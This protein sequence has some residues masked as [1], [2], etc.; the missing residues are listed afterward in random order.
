[1]G[2]AS[3]SVLA[4]L[5]IIIFIVMNSTGAIANIGM[6][7]FI[8]GNTWK[9]SS[10]EYGAVP[11]I[12]GTI[13]V[14]VGSVAFAVPLGIGAA[15][16]ISE[17]ADSKK[18]KFLKPIVELF[19]GIPSVVYGFIGLTLMTPFFGNL[20]PEQMPTGF[21]WITGSI[22]LGLMALPTIISVSEDSIKAVP[23]SYREASLAMGATKWETTMKVVVPA[24]ISGIS[25]AV[26]LGIGRAMG[27]T[28]AVMMVTGNAA[29]IPEPLWNIFSMVRTITASLAL[30]MPEVVVGSVH[31]SSLFLLALILMFL[32]LVINIIAKLIVNHT[33]R[34][35]EAGDQKETKITKILEKINTHPQKKTISKILGNTA[36]FVLVFLMASLFTNI[37]ESSLIALTAMFVTMALKQVYKK[38]NSKIQEK[39]SH[40][41]LFF[42]V[43]LVCVVL[44]IILG[45]ICIKGIPALSW[46][47]ITQ[48]PE[49][50]FTSGGIY[51]AI[52]GTLEL[53]VGTALISIPL[54]LLTG[55]YLAE[56][57]G[58]TKI[59][60]MIRWASDLLNGT[61][62]V[63][64]GLFGM[65]ALVIFL[66]MGQS[67]IAG[68][69]TLSIMA[70]PVIIRTTEE[71][72]KSVPVELREA[73][74]GMG[75]TKW[76]TVSRVVIPSAIGGI[77]TGSILSLGR[78]VGETAPIMF[79]A[80]VLM[81][82]QLAS[83]I[84]EPIMALPY[85]LYYLASEGRADPS[86]QY[87]TALV[88]LIIV[89]AMFLSA[90]YI[91]ERNNKGE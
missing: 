39:I 87:G 31:Y 76:Q 48:F 4:I 58:D 79:T 67:L 64:F 71:A 65:T 17:V 66:D 50:G 12:L 26:I 24:A 16:Y 57:A 33:K 13:L 55:V 60:N 37:F 56:Y 11:V 6:W 19:A 44:V 34:K 62:S 75:A 40:N 84:F 83:S 8:T 46:D 88:L 74:M 80:T 81:Q 90:N 61:P 23:R 2:I 29:V 35:F 30:E 18:R 22:L 28:M 9:P 25:A 85:L 59:S 53:L 41:I 1:M 10:E 38:Q 51:P 82:S 69:I 89:L 68:C 91:R 45:N 15:I 21:A 73:S 52:I 36:I 49:N 5:F 43:I 72:V 27:E 77:V 3:L 14:T 63:V 70:L 7:E 47:F 32:V 42:G 78:A 20:F 86:V 54:G